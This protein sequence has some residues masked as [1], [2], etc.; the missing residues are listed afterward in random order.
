MKGLVV[1]ADGRVG[2][3][4]VDVAAVSVELVLSSRWISL[5]MLPYYQ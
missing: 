1:E 3:T 4:F 5:L 2:R